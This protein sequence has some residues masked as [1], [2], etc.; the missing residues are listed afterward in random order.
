VIEVLK[1]EPMETPQ[2]PTTN[3][4]D[5]YIAVIA[6]K[7][8]N[9]GTKKVWCTMDGLKLMLEQ[10]PNSTIQEQFYNG[11]THDH[12]VTSVLCFCPEG[13]IPI[14]AFKMLG[15]FHDST[16]AES[17]YG[18]VYSEL[19]EMFNK[20]DDAKC[21]ADLVFHEKKYKCIITS[22]QDPLTAQGETR[23]E[24]E[25]NVRIQLEVTSLCQAAK[26]GTR[27][28]QSFFPHLKDRFAYKENGEQQRVLH[29][30]FLLY[31]LRIWM[32][33]INQIHNV[34]MPFLQIEENIYSK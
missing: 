3:K 23:A 2:L 16:V 13:T 5:G 25:Q 4:I 26:W 1:N 31:N 22:S 14:A 11:W 32:V 7:H 20:Y 12:Y 9:L 28:I 8:P 17:E 18:Q 24:V 33:G 34:Y 19:E 21:T 29:S 15:S 10:A 30:L 27:A 6:E